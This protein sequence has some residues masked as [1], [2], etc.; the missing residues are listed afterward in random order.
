MKLKVYAIKD[1]LNGAYMNPFYLQNDNVAIRAFANVIKYGP[2]DN[3][4][5]MNAKDMELYKIGEFDEENGMLTSEI[6]FLTNGANFIEIK[7]EKEEE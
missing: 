5:K 1:T 6:N 4:I 2:D 3:N 7:K